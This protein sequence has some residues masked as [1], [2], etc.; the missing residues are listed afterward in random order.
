MPQDSTVQACVMKLREK[1]ATCRL[2]ELPG[3]QPRPSRADM[4]PD[5]T[6]HVSFLRWSRFVS[7][8]V[9]LYPMPLA[10]S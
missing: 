9:K 4:G 8:V 10:P 2:S 7:T 1:L 6:L 5:L 3:T